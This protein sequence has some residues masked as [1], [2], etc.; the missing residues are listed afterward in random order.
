[1]G[2]GHTMY[3]QLYNRKESIAEVHNNCIFC[4]DRNPL[5]SAL[6]FQTLNDDSVT[7][8]LQGRSFMQGY[9]GV[10]HG[11]FVSALLEEAMVHVL[12]QKKIKGYPINLNVAYF[13]TIPSN[14][15][16]TLKAKLE[17]EGPMIYKLSAELF[18]NNKLVANGRS[19]F[20]NI[21]LFEI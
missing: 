14:A 10:L 19:D 21:K 6:V 1:M 20:A 4:G 8:E 7:A 3:T 15:N 17:G 12:F 11:G 16:L 9:Q 13:R 2:E 18:L 5:S